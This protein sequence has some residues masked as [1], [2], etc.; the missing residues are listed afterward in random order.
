MTIAL[1]GPASHCGFSRSKWGIFPMEMP[2]AARLQT[3]IA[4]RHLRMI[5]PLSRGLTAG[6]HLAC[7]LKLLEIDRTESN[8][9]P[10]IQVQY[11]L[12]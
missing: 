6:T 9:S 5:K 12:V 1:T 8:R 7:A 11:A 10:Y 3:G 4:R 2:F